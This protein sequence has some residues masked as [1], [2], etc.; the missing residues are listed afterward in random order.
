MFYIVHHCS[1]IYLIIYDFLSFRKGLQYLAMDGEMEWEWF[2]HLTATK[3]E[4]ASG[5]VP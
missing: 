1:T 4:Y 3:S 5:R 2:H